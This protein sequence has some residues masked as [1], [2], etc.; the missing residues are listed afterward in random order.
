MEL[1]K[2]MLKSGK[3]ASLR[4]FHPWV[5]SGAIKKIYGGEP[6]EGEVVAVVDN[7]D[8]FLGLGHYQIGSIAIRVFSFEEMPPDYEFWKSKFE[9]A[10]AYRKQLG[11]I[12][13]SHTNV[14]RLIHAEGDGMPG[15][16]MDYYNGTVVM[17]AH[18]IGMHLLR[19][20]FSTILQ[21]LLG[22]DLK[23]IYDKSEAT[24]PHKADI[25]PENGYLY[26]KSE[27]GV[28]EEYGNKFNID[29]VKGQKTG[30]F[31]DQRENRKLLADYSKGKKVCNVFGYS[32]GFSVFALK[33][34]AELVHTVDSSKSAIELTDENV[35]LNFGDNANHEG[36]AMD[37]FDFFDSATED[38]DVIIL[39]PP[40]FA[41]HQKVL[42]NAL[43]G[44]KRLNQRA[45]EQIKPGG[46]IFTFSCSQA[47]SKENF[48]K[49]V[50]VAAANAR[51]NVKILH[52]ISQPTDHPIS[53][54]H[55]ESEYLKGLVLFV[56]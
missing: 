16:I 39:D 25:V 6:A 10:I 20:Q 31:I 1:I 32:G 15:L 49:S 50:F 55:P 13:Q 12:G 5:F 37:A 38:Y 46:I 42:H 21:E 14:Y 17:Q 4:R 19:E 47:V 52:Q 40:A 53:I 8:E 44:Y 56:E 35:K 2:I 7:K 24:L 11:I 54:Y 9:K 41:K 30:F 3:D 33:A 22:D 43:Q 23:A 26:G 48:R 51:R 36:F 29:W 18:S 28:V 27:G 45:L 34:G